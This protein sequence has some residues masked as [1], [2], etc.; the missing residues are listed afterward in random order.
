MKCYDDSN[1]S[2][3]IMYLDG[4]N[5]YGWIVSQYLRYSKFKWLN[6]NEIDKFEVN[7]IGKNSLDGYILEVDLEYHDELH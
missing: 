5:L 7:V 6:Q 4:N 2:K 3:Y 1:R